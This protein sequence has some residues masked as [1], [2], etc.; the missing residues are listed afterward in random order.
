MVREGRAGPDVIR[1][2]GMCSCRRV[3]CDG[4]A[5]ATPAAANVHGGDGQRPIG[6][7]VNVSLCC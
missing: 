5:R 6:P 7:P 3:F 2:G 4:A 1:V